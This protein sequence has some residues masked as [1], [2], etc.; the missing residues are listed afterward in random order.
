MLRI[1]IFL[2]VRKREDL[3]ASAGTGSAD[4]VARAGPRNF[5]ERRRAKMFLAK[6]LLAH[7]FKKRLKIKLI[8]AKDD[9]WIKN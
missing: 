4:M 1:G 7:C 8:H 2:F 9:P 6:S 5:C 3:K